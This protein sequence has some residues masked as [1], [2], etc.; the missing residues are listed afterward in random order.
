VSA[1]LVGVRAALYFVVSFYVARGLALTAS[2]S[3]GHW[4]AGYAIPAAL[5]FLYLLPPRSPRTET[6]R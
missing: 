2:P 6:A 1:L 3:W 4:C 5:V